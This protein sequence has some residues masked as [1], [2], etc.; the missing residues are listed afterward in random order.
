V[1]PP[2]AS[3]PSHSRPWPRPSERSELGLVRGIAFYKLV[4]AILMFLIALAV[5]HLVH[6]NMVEVV[7]RWAEKLHADPESRFVRYLTR[8]VVRVTD[9]QLHW[10]GIGALAYMVLYIIEGIGLMM[11]RRW[12]EWLTVI[13]GLGLVPYETHELIH[14]ASVIKALVLLG[15]L[16]IAA[17]LFHR[18]RVKSAREKIR[19]TELI[20]P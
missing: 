7:T 16:A 12:A 13:A 14:R 20:H 11:D 8:R 3:P 6:H 10:V 15:N 19:Q 4:K 17:F 2:S 5:L 18:L 9:R 1:N